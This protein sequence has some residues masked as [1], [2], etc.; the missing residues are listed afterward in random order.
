VSPV[1]WLM[2][3]EEANPVPVEPHR[4]DLLDHVGEPDLTQYVT[5]QC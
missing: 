4:E 3:L 2:R 5:D 1:S